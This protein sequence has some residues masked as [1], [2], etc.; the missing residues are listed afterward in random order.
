[1]AADYASAVTATRCYVQGSPFAGLFL[2]LDT[3]HPDMAGVCN[4]VLQDAH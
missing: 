2:F 3:L 4:G 1:M